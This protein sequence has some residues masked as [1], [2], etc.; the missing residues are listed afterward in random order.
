MSALLSRLSTLSLSSSL[1]YGSISVILLSD[2][3]SSSSVRMVKISLGM[4]E[5]C[6]F[7]RSRSF[8]LLRLACLKN[9]D[10]SVIIYIISFYIIQKLELY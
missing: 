8:L 3:L 2:R 4:N 6:R 7:D 10:S 5:S 1:I 9:T